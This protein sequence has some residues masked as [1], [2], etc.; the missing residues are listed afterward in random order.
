MSN[1]TRDDY[2]CYENPENKACID[3]VLTN[4]SNSLFRSAVTDT[5]LLDFLK[6][7]TCYNEKTFLKA[8]ANHRR[9]Q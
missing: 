6:N 8:K 2:T 3:I 9:K 4:Q 1:L 7:E 5:L